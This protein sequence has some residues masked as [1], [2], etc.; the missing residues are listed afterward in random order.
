MNGI[1]A[2]DSGNRGSVGATSPPIPWE[3]AFSLLEGMAEDSGEVFPGPR[4]FSSGLTAACFGGASWASIRQVG[5][6]RDDAEGCF[7]SMLFGM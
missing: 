7:G 1:G 6:E 3:V 4:D 2:D 5:R